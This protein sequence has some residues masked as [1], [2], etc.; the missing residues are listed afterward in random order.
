MG[1]KLGE[2]FRK[3]VQK[4]PNFNEK[5][6]ISGQ[7]NKLGLSLSRKKGF[8]G[9]KIGKKIEYKDQTFTNLK[10]KKKIFWVKI[11]GKNVV[12]V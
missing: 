9:P 11:C 1:Q 5:K 8:F 2:N 7:K 3:K 12:L 6:D 10:K 4:L